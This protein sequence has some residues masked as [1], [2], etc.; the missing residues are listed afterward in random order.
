[1]LIIAVVLLVCGG[2]FAIGFGC[3]LGKD[4][5][6]SVLSFLLPIGL[7]ITGACLIHEAGNGKPIGGQLERNAVYERLSSAPD[8]G[9]YVVVLRKQNGDVV[10]HLLDKNPPLAS[11]YF[12]Y[13]GNADNPYQ[14]FLPVPPAK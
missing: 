2:I 1:M 12:K 9:K 13:T 6:P 10:V 8:N 14:L 7:I 11:N 4:N 5:D 3:E